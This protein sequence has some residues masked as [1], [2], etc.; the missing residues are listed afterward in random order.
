MADLAEKLAA[1]GIKDN[2]RDISNKIGRGTF[3]RHF[4][5]SSA[6]KQ[7]AATQSILKMTEAFWL[8]NL[9]QQEG[10]VF[11]D[12]FQRSFAQVVELKDF[13]RCRFPMRPR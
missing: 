12:I 8:A 13:L 2:E 10:L 6:W 11:H 9:A 3:Y 4:F 7:L 1:I 5:H